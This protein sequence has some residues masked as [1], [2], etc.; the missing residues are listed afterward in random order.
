LLLFLLIS[1]DSFFVSLSFLTAFVP[2][3]SES[4]GQK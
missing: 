2:E 3:L 1:F 4:S